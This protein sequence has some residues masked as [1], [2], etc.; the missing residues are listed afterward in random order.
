MAV[1]TIPIFIGVDAAAAAIG[2]VNAGST[3]TFDA[4]TAHIDQLGVAGSVIRKAYVEVQ[5]QTT[6]GTA[7]TAWDVSLAINGGARSEELV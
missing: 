7:V 3:R 6:S 2:S 5:A 4:V 1:D